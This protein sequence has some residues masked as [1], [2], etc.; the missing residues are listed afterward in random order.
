M[1]AVLPETEVSVSLLRWAALRHSLGAREAGDLLRIATPSIPQLRARRI[2]SLLY[3]ATGNDSA[4][5][6]VYDKVWAL[7]RKAASALL[8]AASD[9]GVFT[10][11]MK[12]SEV[13][14]RYF[15]GRGVSFLNDIDLLVARDDIQAIKRVLYANGYAQHLFDSERQALL[16]RDIREIADIEVNHHE[17]APFNRLEPVELTADEAAFVR[18][19]A[20]HP[21]WPIGDRF[22]AVIEFDVHYAVAYDV[23]GDEFFPRCEQG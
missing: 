2:D 5:Q 8:Q 15:G 9:A 12:G 21:I 13:V 3:L 11:V 1:A 20:W 6:R 18:E 23:E 19:W 22:F 14:N 7:Q 17:L 10:V 16:P 4:A